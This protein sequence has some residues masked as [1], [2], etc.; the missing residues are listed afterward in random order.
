MRRSFPAIVAAFAATGCFGLTCFASSIAVSAPLRYSGSPGCTTNSSTNPS[1][2]EFN[3]K[4]V[5]AGC[6]RSNLSVTLTVSS[7]G[8]VGTKID[9]ESLSCENQTMC[10]LPSH[11]VG[12]SPGMY[13]IP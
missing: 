1:Y 5:M 7:V 8:N 3:L 12:V 9:P 4:G 2:A 13:Y 11:S 6:Y 10:V